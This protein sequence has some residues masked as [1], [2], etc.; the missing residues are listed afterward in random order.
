MMWRPLP[1]ASGDGPRP[2]SAGLGS[3][4]RRLGSAPPSVLAVVFGGWEELV[5]AGLSTHCQPV[6]VRDDALIVVISDPAWATELRFLAP[7]ILRRAEELAG[8]PVAGRL[9]VRV[10]RPEGPR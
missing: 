10:R 5:G 4:A 1:A 6:A 2:L 9:E 7:S 8:R 3:V